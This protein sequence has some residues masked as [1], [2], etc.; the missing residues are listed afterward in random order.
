M[1]Q[2]SI[3]LAFEGELESHHWEQ[4]RD[5]IVDAARDGVTAVILDLDRVTFFDSSAIRA[6]LAARWK[7]EPQGVTIHLGACSPIVGRVVEV[8]GIGQAFPPWPHVPAA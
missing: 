1:V 5:T 4:L 7:L 8:T 3:T 6:L 2:H